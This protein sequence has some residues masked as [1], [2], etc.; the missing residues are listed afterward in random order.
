MQEHVLGLNGIQAS[1]RQSLVADGRE[2]SNYGNDKVTSSNYYPLG[3]ICM[4]GRI[5]I[6]NNHELHVC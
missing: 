5:V 6:I 4:I 3:C 2:W 1:P